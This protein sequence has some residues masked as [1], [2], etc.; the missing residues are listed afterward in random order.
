MQSAPTSDD[1]D[2]VIAENPREDTPADNEFEIT[3]FGRGVGECVAIHLGSGHWCL[4]DSFRHPG[5]HGPAGLHYLTE[6]AIDPGRV[7]L[8]A[9]THFH[10]DHIGGLGDCVETC[11]NA[12]V[13]VPSAQ[14]SSDFLTV[15]NLYPDTE[16]G[17]PRRIREMKRVVASLD[18]AGR[19]VRLA[20]A[21]RSVLLPKIASEL[22]ATH[23]IA[24]PMI[25]ALSP[26]DAL[27]RRIT[28][29]WATTLR[30]G[31]LPGPEA[32]PPYNDTSMVLLVSVGPARVL[33]G[34]DLEESALTG[35]GWKAVDAE[36]PRANVP[37]ADVLKV[38]H[39]GSY[40]ADSPYLWKNLSDTPLGVLTPFNSG[41]TPVPRPTDISRLQR[42]CSV[43]F[44]T[45]TPRRADPPPDTPEARML[46]LAGYPALATEYGA[47]RLR[48]VIDKPDSS[49]EVAFFGA[50]GTIP[51]IS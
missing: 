1:V 20:G 32:K 24:P 41:R 15:L 16:A 7:V 48:R 35:E 49:W 33:L 8:V 37:R 38:P 3:V 47:V 10:M 29:G 28:Q 14:F 42:R 12:L 22:A 43:L 9:G 51:P 45:S 6:R 18:G 5:P 13:A 44:G 23:G 25:M 27:T 40:N 46:S 30:T 39:H 26:S 31:H 2:Y 21:G 34:A 4:V 36:W 50:A 17:A 19:Q 11:R